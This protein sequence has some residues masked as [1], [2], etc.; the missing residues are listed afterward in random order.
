MSFKDWC[1]LYSDLP[2]KQVKIPVPNKNLIRCSTDEMRV[3]DPSDLQVALDTAMH[4]LSQGR[5]F[6]R[7]SG[8]E[9]CVRIY[10]EA[11]SQE[12]ANKLTDEAILAIR[13]FVR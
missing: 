2:S 10:A 11:T 5:A 7:P 4:R 6:V 13:Y 1:G 12:D 8:T 3:E 9:D